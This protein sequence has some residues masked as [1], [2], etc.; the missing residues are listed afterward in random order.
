MP[1]ITVKLGDSL[2][3]EYSFDSDEVS[4]GRA[5]DNNIVLE[6]LSVSRNHAKIQR[7]GARYFVVDLG[8]ANGTFVNG[9]RVA[10]VEIQDEDVIAI[11]KHKLRFSLRAAEERGAEAPARFDADRT[12]RVP[13]EPVGLLTVA[14]EKQGGQQ[15][16]VDRYET[17]IG[18]GE[19]C[20][21][22]LY[23]WTLSKRHA[24]LCRESGSFSLRDLGKLVGVK[25]NGQRVR[26][27]HALYD[28]DEIR[29]GPFTMIFRILA[30]A[31]GAEAP[32]DAI[33][34]M[35]MEAPAPP[36][37][38][39]PPAREA[40][41]AEA[42]EEFRAEPWAE[43]ME[44]P[45]EEPSPAAAPPPAESSGF[46]PLEEEAAVRYES[47][48]K[49]APE[50]EEPA[51]PETAA[52]EGVAAA[53]ENPP[54]IA[55]S[56]AAEAQLAERDVPLEEE[57]AELADLTPEEPASSQAPPATPVAAGAEEAA[58]EAKEARPAADPNEIALWERALDNPSPAIRRE[59]AR[60]LKKMTGR[61]YDV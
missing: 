4:I 49:A 53:L 52:G 51:A 8:S 28:S 33:P 35:R 30:S 29:I 42:I 56:L 60:R 34:E 19:D 58:V 45:R 32:S 39:P 36:V 23:D 21:V 2:V 9:V 31:P 7:E 6:T 18:R 10:K 57:P 13:T 44:G 47:F 40:E 17:M 55:E 50:G 61:D 37:Q 15:F 25:V 54:A 1:V 11:G 27:R 41:P 26:E 46:R 12:V 43:A 22:R 14:S 16:V 59:A 38:E 5:K 3:Q 24:V 48:V 20:H